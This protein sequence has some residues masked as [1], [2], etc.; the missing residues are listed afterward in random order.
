M[1]GSIPACLGEPGP[2][3]TAV[4]AQEGDHLI[5]GELVVKVDQEDALCQVFVA[6]GE[7]LAQGTH[8]HGGGARRDEGSDRSFR[9][10][11]T[12]RRH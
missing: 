11:K 5:L 4:C 9:T 8:E 6:L 7:A 2:Y 1:G 3:E 12:M 10:P